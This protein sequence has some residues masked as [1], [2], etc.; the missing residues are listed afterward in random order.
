MDKTATL[1]L[2]NRFV[3]Y[4][5]NNMNQPFSQQLKI[6]KYLCATDAK[7]VILI[8]ETEDCKIENVEGYK[9]PNIDGILP[10]FK[11]EIFI[12]FKN[13]SKLYYDIPLVERFIM[14][15][16]DSCDGAGQFT[17]YG[18]TYECKEC[19]EMG[20]IQTHMTEKVK[21]PNTVFRFKEMDIDI[22]Y[23]H[24]LIEVFNV[25]KPKIF[26]IVKLGGSVIWFKLD[27]VYIG[28]ACMYNVEEE[29]KEW[30]IIN[31]N[32]K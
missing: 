14:Q 11:E 17:H 5:R 21:N 2:L 28:V 1:K 18:N 30:D 12:D 16:C 13:I 29:K 23:V 6:G 15:E 26:S 25:V 10:E 22:K 32:L 19:D 8:P 24:E 7:R 20:E 27:L 31:V 9:P 4:N 3:D